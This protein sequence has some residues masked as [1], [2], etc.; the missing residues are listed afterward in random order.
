MIFFTTE[1][2]YRERLR[3]C[4]ACELFNAQLNQCKKCKCI[5][6]VKAKFEVAECPLKK[7]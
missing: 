7:W 2:I 1:H 6:T 3:H 4:K 5:M